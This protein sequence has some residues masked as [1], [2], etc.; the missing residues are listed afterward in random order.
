[1]QLNDKNYFYDINKAKI[2]I[3]SLNKILILN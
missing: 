2:K 1:M 3:K